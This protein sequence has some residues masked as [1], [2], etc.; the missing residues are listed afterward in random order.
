MTLHP[1]KPLHPDDALIP[2]KLDKFR[3]LTSD[4]L[5]NSLLPSQTGSL[6]TR[7]DGTVLDGHHRL[8]VLRE[9]GIDVNSLPR[10]L[11][12]KA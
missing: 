9:R 12:S 8:K 7:P 4:E 10:E 5:I 2:L 1:L 6:K 11:I 3:T